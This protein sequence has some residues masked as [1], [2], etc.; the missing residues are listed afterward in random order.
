MILAKSLHQH[1][2][3][4]CYISYLSPLLKPL[5]WLPGG[6]RIWPFLF[7]F[8]SHSASHGA[9]NFRPCLNILCSPMLI[10][11]SLSE[12]FSQL[13]YL[14]FRFLL[15]PPSQLKCFSLWNFLLRCGL[16]INLHRS[17]SVLPYSH[18]WISGIKHLPYQQMKS[19][20]KTTKNSK[21][22]LSKRMEM[23]NV[24]LGRSHR[25]TCSWSDIL[26]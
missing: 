18:E 11:I 10:S 3:A 5:Q 26:H 6:Y 8:V 21:P 4:S 22:H 1:I 9:L 14:L 15:F 2:V 23:A 7:S 25:V 19:K 17:Q 16:K 20:N 12:I 24:N 13:S